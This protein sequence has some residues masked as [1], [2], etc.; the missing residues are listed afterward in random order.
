MFTQVAARVAGYSLHS[1]GCH[2]TTDWRCTFKSCPLQTLQDLNKQIFL[3]KQLATIVSVQ[4]FPL[5][6]SQIY[7]NKHW[8]TVWRI[9]SLPLTYSTSE[10]L[11][12]LTPVLPHLSSTGCTH[13]FPLSHCFH[14]GVKWIPTVC[15]NAPPISGCDSLS[16]YLPFSCL[17]VPHVCPFIST[18]KCLAQ[19]HKHIPSEVLIELR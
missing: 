5:G 19:F 10:K 7:M 1:C 16:P 14:L 18:D 12:G 17:P 6:L 3:N 8:S 2:R 15:Q 9:P 4:C 11:T 13:T